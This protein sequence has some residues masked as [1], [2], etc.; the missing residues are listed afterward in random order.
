MRLR[1]VLLVTAIAAAPALAVDG[2]SRLVDDA[3]VVVETAPDGRGATLVKTTTVL[4]H[5]PAAVRAALLDFP[6]YP[7]WFTSLAAW[8]VLARG[9]DSAQVYG[10]HDLPWPFA[11]RD[12]VVRY[13]WT[14]GGDG[15]LDLRAA[16]V[17]EGAPPPASGVVR[18]TAARSSWVVA[19]VPGGARV[20]YTYGTDLGGVPDLLQQGAWKSEGP[21]LLRALDK[22]LSKRPVPRSVP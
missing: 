9:A 16:S 11:P 14:Q 20:V 7:T 6:G 5:P 22:E 8:R 3:A 1:V 2:W 21:A 19:A 13:T 12:Y 10:R 4:P 18:L 17:T 15:S